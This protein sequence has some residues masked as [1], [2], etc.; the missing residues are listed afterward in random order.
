MSGVHWAWIGATRPHENTNVFQWQNGS[1]L[2]F[3]RWRS[4]CPDN[5]KGENCVLMTIFK[6]RP[7]HWC[8]FKCD[9]NH[10]HVVCEKPWTN[11]YQTETSTNS[12]SYTE[13][14][15]DGPCPIGWGFHSGKCY[16]LHNANVTGDEARHICKHE[17]NAT[18]L[19]IHSE[20]EQT[21]IIDYIFYENGAKEAF[22]IG[23]KRRAENDTTFLWIDNQ[24]LDYQNWGFGEPDNR[25]VLGPENCVIVN[26]MKSNFGRWCDVPCHVEFLL[27]CE[28]KAKSVSGSS[29]ASA[30]PS[31][32]PRIDNSGNAEKGS[33]SDD[34]DSSRAGK[35]LTIPKAVCTSNI[36]WYVLVVSLLLMI[37]TLV[38]VIH[39]YRKK[40]NFSN[41]YSSSLNFSN[42]SYD[43]R[44]N[45]Y[46]QECVIPEPDYS[47]IT[48]SA[49]GHKYPPN[50]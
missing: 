16:K 1:E 27:V 15:Y 20:E 36:W 25:F 31:S 9:S 49:A 7:S 30:V 19:T 11:E 10:D 33:A 8:N 18:M 35:T 50:K 21:F 12:V 17:Y 39:M 13:E 41:A 32:Q 6:D 14:T 44:N 45:D 42:V 5:R 34:S 47:E 29:T 22:W 26:D 48:Y 2:N 23:L 43:T 40:I 4:G 24:P 38:T 3:T 37:A 28:R 46:S